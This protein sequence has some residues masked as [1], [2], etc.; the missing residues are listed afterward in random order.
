MVYDTNKFITKHYNIQNRQQWSAG[1]F[2]H[3]GHIMTTLSGKPIIN[4][5]IHKQM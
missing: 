3:G 4:G 2:Q 5:S 1:K